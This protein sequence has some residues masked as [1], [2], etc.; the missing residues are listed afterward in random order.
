MEGL[1]TRMDCHATSTM[2]G[3]RIG[4]PAVPYFGFEMNSTY[5]HVDCTKLTL[6]GS[7]HAKPIGDIICEKSRSIESTACSTVGSKYHS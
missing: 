2:Y 3:L 4:Y 6:H 5:L 7:F 1:G